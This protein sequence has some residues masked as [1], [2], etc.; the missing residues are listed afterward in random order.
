MFISTCLEHV[1][2]RHAFKLFEHRID[3]KIASSKFGARRLAEMKKGAE[4]ASKRV[5]A[6]FDHII[7]RKYLRFGQMLASKTSEAI[8]IVFG[9]LLLGVGGRGCWLGGV[10][11]SVLSG[12]WWC[13]RWWQLDSA[14]LEAIGELSEHR[15]I[16]EE[17]DELSAR[18][19][20]QRRQ[21]RFG[22]LIIGIR[23]LHY[24]KLNRVAITLS[25]TFLYFH[26]ISHIPSQPHDKQPET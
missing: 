18:H 21:R 23:S 8:K 22:G 7:T 16:L 13:R 17:V 2:W 5:F 3:I 4:E 9:I 15:S 20:A 25:L 26:H 6:L 10:G 1:F 14:R 12:G 24:L 19:R 11:S